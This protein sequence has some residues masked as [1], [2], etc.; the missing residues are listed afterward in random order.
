MYVGNLNL[1]YPFCSLSDAQR[2]ASGRKQR[3]RN[4]FTYTVICYLTS[5]R[6]LADQIFKVEIF[7]TEKQ[8]LGKSCLTPTLRVNNF[9]TFGHTFDFTLLI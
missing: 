7:N 3:A 8:L 4:I 5:V 9:H 1:E 6:A 2:A